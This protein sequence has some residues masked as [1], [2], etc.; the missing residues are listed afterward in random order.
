MMS[1]SL[2]ERTMGLPSLFFD[3]SARREDCSREVVVWK[4][5]SLSVVTDILSGV[6]VCMC[7]CWYGMYFTIWSRV[8]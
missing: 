6:L 1:R 2:E 5:W 3:L 8:V 7:V 4:K